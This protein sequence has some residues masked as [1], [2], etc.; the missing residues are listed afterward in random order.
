MAPA[1]LAAVLVPALIHRPVAAAAEAKQADE[2]LLAAL[3]G[4]APPAAEVE[5][6]SPASCVSLISFVPETG[7]C[8]VD[9]GVDV[10]VEP[11]QEPDAAQLV[12]LVDT[13]TASPL[14]LLGLHMLWCTPKLP[15]HASLCLLLLL[16]FSCRRI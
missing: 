2:L 10:T 12:A 11:G 5:D 4:A 13:V 3:I 16:L 15:P 7:G 1:D 14:G 9:G 8:S 6:G